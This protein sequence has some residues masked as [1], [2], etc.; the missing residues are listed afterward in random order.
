MLAAVHSSRAKNTFDVFQTW[1]ISVP[2]SEYSGNT[3][4][5]STRMFFLEFFSH[6][7]RKLTLNIN[8]IRFPMLGIVDCYWWDQERDIQIKLMILNVTWMFGS[9]QG[10]FLPISQVEICWW[11]V[12][13]SYSNLLSV[14]CLKST[15][16]LSLFE[17]GSSKQP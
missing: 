4:F 6:N 10:W 9:Q 17:L 3:H 15:F 16:K 2:M 12:S 1:F 5:I 7:N 8:R 11:Q 13:N 14:T